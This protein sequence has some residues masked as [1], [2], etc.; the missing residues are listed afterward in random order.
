L[1]SGP[2]EGS[3]SGDRPE[4]AGPRKGWVAA[5]GEEGR[6]K[7]ERRGHGVKRRKEKEIYRKEKSGERKKRN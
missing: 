7:E 3:S 1:R 4:A 5:K 6:R 2:G